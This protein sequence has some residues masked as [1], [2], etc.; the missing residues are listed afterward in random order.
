MEKDLW[1]YKN[2]NKG[3]TDQLVKVKVGFDGDRDSCHAK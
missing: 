3:Y 2:I 1:E